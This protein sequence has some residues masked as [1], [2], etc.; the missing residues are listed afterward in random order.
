MAGPGFYPDAKIFIAHPTHSLIHLFG[1]YVLRFYPIPVSKVLMERQKLAD[2]VLALVEI[3][4]L[5][6][7]TDLNSFTNA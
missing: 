2:T 3:N 4:D 6:A 5:M 7:E 1:K